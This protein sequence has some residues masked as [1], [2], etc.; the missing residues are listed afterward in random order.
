[1]T[2]RRQLSALVAVL[3]V[4]AFASAATYDTVN[5][6][7]E[8]P[9]ARLAKEFGDKAEEYR[10]EKA[11]EWTGREMPQWPS[12]CPLLVQITQGSAGGATTFT[13]GQEG[14]RSVVTSIRME[15][16][17]DAAQLLN[18]VLPHEVTH[19]VLANYFGRP[20]PRWADEGGSVLSENDDERFNHNVRCRELLNAGRGIRCRVLFRM[21]EYPKDMIV[22]YA[23]GYSVS[24]YLVAKGGDGRE[25]RL[26]LLQ[27]LGTGMQGNSA[28]SWNA[29]AHKVYGFESVDELE[30][31]WLTSLKTPPT[32]VVARDTTPPA[33]QP[34]SARSPR[35]EL[36]TS[37]A[38]AV[39]VLEAP[40]RVRGATPDREPGRP[41]YLPEHG[42]TP[43]TK[44]ATPNL[45]VPE[46]LPPE[47]P[48]P[49]SP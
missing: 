42:S 21:T 46:L 43:V 11:L 17:G 15:I 36:R 44:P 49:V 35:T 25:G 8:A 34:T 1:M 20:V 18:S 22:L 29:A 24:H 31:A 16:R 37:A 9:T 2:L 30:E 33:G 28:E 39:P 45:P 4:P 7:T 47:L 40:V 41:S 38:P 12:R 32:R 5:F 23:Q 48:R 19:T 27:F 3:F 10:R 6:R 14:G 26:K 13:F